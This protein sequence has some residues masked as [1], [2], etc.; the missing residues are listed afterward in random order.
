M[1]PN[2]RPVVHCFAAVTYGSG[3]ILGKVHRVSLEGANWLRQIGY[4][5]IGPDPLEMCDLAKWE[6]E[7]GPLRRSAS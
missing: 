7:H 3:H 5:I 2:K 6:K 1:D 4:S